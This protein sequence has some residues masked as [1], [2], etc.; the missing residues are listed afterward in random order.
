LFL[1]WAGFD[2][3]DKPQRDIAVAHPWINPLLDYKGYLRKTEELIAANPTDQSLL[4]TRAIQNCLCGRYA[5]AIPDLDMFWNAGDRSEW[6]LTFRAFATANQNREKD[7]IECRDL[8]L[9]GDQDWGNRFAVEV[10]TAAFLGDM[11]TCQRLFADRLAQC[12]TPGEFRDLAECYALGSA[13]SVKYPE[14]NPEFAEEA[15]KII[16]THLAQHWEL[17]DYVINN[18]DFIQIL[19][20]PDIQQL[21]RQMNVA[22]V[23]DRRPDRET[24]LVCGQRPEDI[25]RQVRELTNDHW[26]PVTIARYHPDSSHARTTFTADSQI[27]VLMERPII[28]DDASDALAVKQ[29][30]AAVA[31]LRLDAPARV[32]PLLKDSPDPSV[33]SYVLHRLPRYGLD[34]QTLIKQLAAETDAGRRRA[35]IQGLGELAATGLITDTVKPTLI[36]DLLARYSS[37][38]DSGVHG[39]CEWTLRQLGAEQQLVSIQQEFATGAAVGDRR[40]Y[41]TKT[42]GETQ[43]DT[44]ISLAIVDAN[45]EFRMGSPLSESGRDSDEQLHRRLI[46]RVYAIGMH[47]IT[48]AQFQRFRPDHEHDRQYWRVENAPANC[49]SWYAAAEFCNW[50]SEEEGI[51][52]DQWCYDPDQPF[53]SGMRLR[54]NYLQLTGY[55]LPTEAEWEHACRGGTSTARFYGSGEGLLGDYGRYMFPG[56]TL[57]PNAYGLYGV[58]GNAWEW[59]QDAYVRDFQAETALLCDV[60]QLESLDVVD[61][62]NRVLRG[63]SFYNTPTNI[64]CAIRNSTVPE[65]HGSLLG[66]RVSRTYPLPP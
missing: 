25:L 12:R 60:E 1:C 13:P 65:I 57:R 2:R 21:C 8:Y 37:D 5:E 51:P 6:L 7:A 18:V 24:R 66:F 61:R 30:S 49:I 14:G 3:I 31:L 15:V 20:H 63:G 62:K 26:R 64:R 53:E 50:L 34:A 47:E 11:A 43:E 55:R 36:S 45:Q 28:S 59:C 46:S 23:F 56:A 22:S 35:L 58:Y 44:A 33:R 39:I 10:I 27:R 52:R 54:P 16:K 29:A 38:P 32:W 42:G 48:M 17:F 19:D 40:W 9:K 4:K 41:L